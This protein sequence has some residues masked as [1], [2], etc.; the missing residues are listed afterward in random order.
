MNYSLNYNEFVVRDDIPKLDKFFRGKIKEAVERKLAVDPVFYGKPL[1]NSLRGHRR[2][3][4]GK[5]RVI[6]RIEG[7]VVLILAIAKRAVVYKT[8][9]GRV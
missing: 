4:I 2:F 9:V 1:R 6:Y 7:E 3:R 5:Y 8:V